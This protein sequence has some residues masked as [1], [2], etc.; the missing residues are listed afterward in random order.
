LT[1]EFCEDGEDDNDY[2][3][4]VLLV[5]VPYSYKFKGLYLLVKDI[6]KDNLSD[7][8]TDNN[9]NLKLMNVYYKEPK[10]NH[11]SML[12]SPHISAI[13]TFIILMLFLQTPF[14]WPSVSY[15]TSSKETAMI[16]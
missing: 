12:S 6:M 14:E 13:A 2:S 5:G 4:F 1:K 10:G 8:L 16:I 7:K 9:L 11:R 15:S 3:F